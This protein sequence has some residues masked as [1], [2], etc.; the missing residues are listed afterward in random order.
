MDAELL[1]AYRRTEYRV[2]DAGHAFVLRIDVPSAELRR[3]HELFGVSCSAFLTA[4]NPRSTPTSREQND[5]AMSRLEQAL[6]ALGCRWLK[7]EGV[8]PKGE[9]PG[10]PSLLV[11]GVDEPAGVALANRFDQNAIVWS[12]AD[13]IPRLVLA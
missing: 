4:W 7:G 12:G 2:D 13:A 5:V 6:T 8:D 1:A 3:C 9:W 10:E 11:F